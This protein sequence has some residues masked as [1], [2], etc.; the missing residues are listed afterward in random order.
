M[1]LQHDAHIYTQYEGM[2][3]ELYRQHDARREQLARKLE[4]AITADITPDYEHHNIAS[5]SM[6]IRIARYD[7]LMAGSIRDND[8]ALLRDWL[9]IWRNIP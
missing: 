5:H 7:L 1:E 3:N 8:L 4:D 6:A 9:G 2:Y